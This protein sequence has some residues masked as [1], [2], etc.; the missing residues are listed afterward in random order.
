MPIYLQ[1]VKEVSPSKSSVLVL[2]TIV[3]ITISV[4]FSGSAVS[5]LGYYAPFMLLTCIIAPAAAG[6]LTTLEV[7]AVLARVICYQALFGLACGFGYQNPQVAA[8]TILDPKDAAIGIALIQF[9]NLFGPAVFVSVAQTVFTGRL[10]ADLENFAPGLSDPAALATNGL[11]NLKER[12]GMEN[13]EVALMGYDKALMHTF[14]LPVALAC[15]GL[16]GA[17]G[18]DWRSVKKKKA[19]NLEGVQG[20]IYTPFSGICS[21][22]TCPMQEGHTAFS[23]AAPTKYRSLLLISECQDALCKSSTFWVTNSRASLMSSRL[24]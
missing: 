18:M 19:S 14:Y 3:G 11:A 12:I 24:D 21:R 5:I 7:N 4:L 20:R 13:L 9:T 16:L 23:G 8:Q 6:L 2:L 15:L 10:I 1:V 22:G 17:V